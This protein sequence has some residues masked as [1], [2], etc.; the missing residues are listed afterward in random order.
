MPLWIL[1][2]VKNIRGFGFFAHYWRMFRKDFDFCSTVAWYRRRLFDILDRLP[3]IIKWYRLKVSRPLVSATV[4]GSCFLLSVAK[5]SPSQLRETISKAAFNQFLRISLIPTFLRV[6]FVIFFL[7]I[8]ALIKIPGA[9]W[10]DPGMTT[11]PA[12]MRP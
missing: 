2:D 3:E 7:I 6:S 10:Y 8:A 4:L 12:G 1:L 9:V 11:D 5:F